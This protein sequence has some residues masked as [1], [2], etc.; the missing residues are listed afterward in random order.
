MLLGALLM[1][2]SLAARAQG[3]PAQEIIAYVF[4]NLPD[5]RPLTAGDVNTTQLTRINYAF[6]LIKDGRVVEGAPNDAANLALLRSLRTAQPGLKLVISVGGWLGSGA[7]SDAALTAASRQRFIDSALTFLTKYD[8]DGLDIDWEYPGLAGAGNKFR[9]EDGA[10]FNLLLKELRAR[11]DDR[12]R[13]TKRPLVLSIAAGA[14]TQFLQHTAMAEAQRYLDQ[15]NLMTYDF[16]EAG[17]G[18]PSLTGNHAPLSADPADPQKA[19][20]TAMVEAFEQAG[21]PPA[22]LVLGVPFY[23]HAWANVPPA[24][25]GLFQTGTAAAGLHTGYTDMQ[26]LLAN[27]FTRYWD[28]DAQVPYAYNSATRQFITYEDPESLGRK[29]NFVLQRQLG[30]VMFWQYLSDPSGTLLNTIYTALHTPAPA[31][32]AHP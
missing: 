32:E 1:A 2:L 20:A 26:T 18:G 9:P 19:S 24:N 29:C 12:T 6:A 11:F 4:P 23:G 15:V 30:G 13:H 21:V 25:H 14:S 27:G 5:D 8:L 31:A 16:Y 17:S 22:K 7:F 10:N 3:T 28:D